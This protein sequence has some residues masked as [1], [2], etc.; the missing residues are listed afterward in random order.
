MERKSAPGHVW[1]TKPVLLGQWGTGLTSKGV[2]RAE[3]QRPTF[4]R[5]VFFSSEKLKIV[6]VMYYKDTEE[7]TAEGRRMASHFPWVRGSSSVGL[8]CP[9]PAADSSLLPLN[10]ARPPGHLQRETPGKEQ[11]QEA[12]ESHFRSEFHLWNE[13]RREERMRSNVQLQLFS[14]SKKSACNTQDYSFF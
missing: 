1:D 8:S 5:K 11:L 7:G 4:D 12:T 3:G 13:M 14:S 2:K 9:V 6:T 10:P